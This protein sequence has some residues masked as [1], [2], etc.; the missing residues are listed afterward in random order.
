M[1][2]TLTARWGEPGLWTRDPDKVLIELDKFLERNL[3][4][5]DAARMSCALLFDYAQYLV[6]A[7]DLDSLRAATR[8]V[9]SGSW[10]GPPIRTSAPTTWASS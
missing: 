4:E 7:G 1:V 9:W 8:R 10:P 3:I 5:P 2:N 6:P